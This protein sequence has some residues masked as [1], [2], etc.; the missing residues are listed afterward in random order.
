VLNPTLFSLL[1]ARFDS[2]K[3]VNENQR[4]L[5]SYQTDPISGRQ[6]F[7]T[8]QAGENY[9]INCCYCSDTRHRL[10]IS[11]RYGIWDDEIHS[12]GAHLALCFNENCLADPGN[13]EKLFHMIMGHINRNQRK[14]IKL[15]ETYEPAS[16]SNPVKPELPSNV[17]PLLD[18]PVDHAARIYVRERGYDE[19]LLSNT[20]AIGYCEHAIKQH[21]LASHRLIIP[22]YDVDYNLQGYQARAIFERNF[23]IAG[24]PKYFTM[25]GMRKSEMLYGMWFYDPDDDPFVIVTEGPFDAISTGR[26]AVAIFGKKPS[27]TQKNLICQYWKR[28]VILL[29]PDAQ[30]EALEFRDDLIKMGLEAWNVKLPNGYDAGSLPTHV[31]ES[32]IDAQTNRDYLYEPHCR[33]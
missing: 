14:Q 21:S 10:Y 30:K 22:I 16:I 2:V 32:T 25:Y 11:Y 33:G 1:K 13:R 15:N 20:Y 31:I 29:D 12:Y 9:A 26:R 8:R 5:G 4:A 19:E 3:I 17:I 6:K 27:I 18:L 24:I 28:V 23:K 7:K